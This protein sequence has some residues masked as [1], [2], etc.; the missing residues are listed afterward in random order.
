MSNIHRL[1]NLILIF[2]KNIGSIR[3][4]FIDRSIEKIAGII[5]SYL[6]FESAPVNGMFQRLDSRVKILFMIF[7]L[8][9]VSLKKD[10]KSEILIFLII[11]IFVYFSKLKI[12]SFYKRVFFLGFIFGFLV[13]LPSSLNFITSGEI[14]LPLVHLNSSK[15]FW[16]YHIP[17]VIGI[18]AEGLTGTIMLTLRVINSLS[19]SFLVV[20]TTKFSEMIRAFKVLKIPDT[21]LMIISIT[22][23][24]IFIFARTVEDIYF[25]MKSRITG[26]LNRSEMRDLIAGRMAFMFKKSRITCEDVYRAMISRGFSN[27][28]RIYSFNRMRIIDWFSGIMLLIIGII[29]ILK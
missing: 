7:F 18:T 26:S 14:I 17:S 20:Y 1:R 6:L 28:I 8:I 29:I 13:A 24:Y 3:L 27:E 21:F 5:K 23:K 9:I 15:D 4:S 22:Y 10:I 12:F 11:Y 25:S 16:I 19:I 2:K